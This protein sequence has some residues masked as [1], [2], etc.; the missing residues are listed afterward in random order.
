[1]RIIVVDDEAS[2][3]QTTTICLESMGHQCVTATNGAD[4]LKEVEKSHFDAAILDLRLN[5]ENGLDVLDKLLQAAPQLAVVV[6]TAYSSVE[7]A[8]EAM[9]RGAHDYLS[10]PFTPDQV[11][12][13]F[14]RIARTR[15]ME[16]RLAEL[17]SRADSAPSEDWSTDEPVMQRMYS[18]V[19]KA[20]STPTTILILGPSGTG[21]SVLARQIH[22]ASPLKEN[23]FVTVNCPCL[24]REL[25]ESTLF[26]H[27]KGAFTGAV[28]DTWGKVAAADGG[29]LFLDEIGELP[30]EMQPKLLRLLQ[31]REYERVGE[32][33][34]RR[35]NVR[36]IAA[37]NRD[38]GQAVREGKFREDLYYR[39]N[40]VSV[41]MP[42]LAARRRDLKR[43]ALEFLQSLGS[44]AGKPGLNFS[45]AAWRLIEGYAWPG[46]LREL[47][48]IIERSVILAES[49]EVDIADLPDMPQASNTLPTQ[50]GSSISLAQL[51]AEH[52]RLV[53]AK[54]RS[55]EEAA[56]ILGIDPATLYRKRKRMEAPEQVE[57]E[58]A[59]S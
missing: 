2:I 58:V 5:Q 19:S 49:S 33:K 6:F 9:R 1:M 36:L 13:T 55:R 59:G 27:V 52:I 56:A 48:N 25:L 38:L 53:V 54:T 35:A 23:P 34:T 12:Q 50:L 37:T 43:L 11:R 14:A 40:V 21:K 4:A 16:I 3:R 30:L 15:Q 51:E 10:K 47:R 41:N 39:L 45:P 31:E 22:Q 29:T 20:A 7:T 32:T 42:P 46:N 17:E 26:G 18:L 8:V 44:Q 24:S 57:S 28:S